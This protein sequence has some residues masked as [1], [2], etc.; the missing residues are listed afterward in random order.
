MRQPARQSLLLLVPVAAAL[1]G[2]GLKALAEEGHEI[3]QKGRAFHPKTVAIGV[4]ETLEFDNEDEFIHQIYVASDEI[5]YDSVEQ[6]PGQK[7]HVTF[8]AAGTFP[9]RC[10][11]HPKMLLTVTVK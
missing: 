11:I 3:I 1:L 4:G 9:V 2:T 8:T 7:L 5:K 6:P 10:H